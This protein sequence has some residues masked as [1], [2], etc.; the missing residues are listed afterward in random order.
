MAMKGSKKAVTEYT[1]APK[2]QPH[3]FRTLFFTRIVNLSSIGVDDKLLSRLIDC[4]GC[5][6]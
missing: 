6:D 2:K 4:C 1:T 5:C 3:A